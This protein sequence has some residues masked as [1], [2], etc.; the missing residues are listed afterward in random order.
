MIFAQTPINNKAEERRFW[1]GR[2][3]ASRDGAGLKNIGEVPAANH[4]VTDG[5]RLMTGAG[6]IKAL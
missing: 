1:K 3:L 5:T 2:L 6:Y 4:W